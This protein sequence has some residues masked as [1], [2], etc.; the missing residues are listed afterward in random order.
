MDQLYEN[1]TCWAP[2]VGQ[3]SSLH[4]AE[5]AAP[6]G[7]IY[8]HLVAVQSIIWQIRML[9]W[10][11]P[12]LDTL[13]TRKT[14]PS[15]DIDLTWQRYTCSEARPLRYHAR[16][17][18]HFTKQL[19]ELENRL[20]NRGDKYDNVGRRLGPKLSVE[21]RL[22]P[23]TQYGDSRCGAVRRGKWCRGSSSEI[24]N[25]GRRQYCQILVGR[26]WNSVQRRTGISCGSRHGCKEYDKETDTAP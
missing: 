26:G 11:E 23:H 16:Q 5:V 19:A 21:A 1:I 3:T 15:R 25:E 12:T 22:D 20:V 14:W 7:K 17:W 2:M 8:K 10:K 24:S 13:N 6:Q 18:H 4:C 9:P